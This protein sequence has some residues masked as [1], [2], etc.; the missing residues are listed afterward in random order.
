MKHQEAAQRHLNLAK[1]DDSYCTSSD[2]DN[3]D[4][5]D[6][7]DVF[8]TLVKSFNLPSGAILVF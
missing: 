1:E 5:T 4:D 7:K 3:N 2:D 8:R 6:D